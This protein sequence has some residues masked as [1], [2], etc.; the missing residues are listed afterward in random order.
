M[1][2]ILTPSPDQVSRPQTAGNDTCNLCVWNI[3]RQRVHGR[4]MRTDRD[5]FPR[6]LEAS[7]FPASRLPSMRR[8]ATSSHLEE[9][10][11]PCEYWSTSLL[12]YHVKS[13]RNCR[14]PDCKREGTFLP[15]M[16]PAQ[17]KHNT[18]PHGLTDRKEA[19][20]GFPPQGFEVFRVRVRSWLEYGIAICT[21]ERASIIKES[22]GVA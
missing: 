1:Y 7:L 17:C 15:C 8:R 20:L 16:L 12:R 5:M 21:G 18:P 4:T 6:S 10:S 13:G 9:M 19:D 3:V 2:P 14:V 11:Q 22:Y